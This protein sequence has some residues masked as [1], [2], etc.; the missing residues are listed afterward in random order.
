MKAERASVLIVDDTPD[1]L[2]LLLE[3]L[4][5]D[6]QVSAATS[7]EY[8]LECVQENLPDLI[9]LDVMMPNMDGYEV[10]QQLKSNPKTCD[11]PVIFI[12]ALGDVENETKGLQMGAIDYIHKPF[13]PPSVK[14]RVANHIALVN[15]SKERERLK[16]NVDNIMRHDLK[17]PLNGILGLSQLLLQSPDID[18]KTYFKLLNG[19][20]DAGHLMLNMI[21]SS[22]DLYKMETGVYSLQTH[23]ID[24]IP[25]LKKAISENYQLIQAYNLSSEVFLNG[26][27]ITDA[28]FFQVWGEENLCYS[29]FS[30]LI[31]NAFEAAPE[32]STVKI[33]LSD[34]EEMAKISICNQG[35]V[36]EDVRERFFDKYVTHKKGGT[37]L[38]TYSAYLATQTQNGTIKLNCTEERTTIVTL[39]LPKPQ[40]NQIQ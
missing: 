8:A 16:E 40:N 1:N 14:I 32:Q 34:S 20:N 2:M 10:C 3:T 31:K 6:Y 25:I 21:N 15:A 24:L 27:P 30:N 28:N 29:A 36:P 26:D 7:G 39:Q 11:I 35:E 33:L 12:T 18:K 22:L 9:L 37:G 4:Q 38:G 17:N 19:I 13:N 23:E 5:N